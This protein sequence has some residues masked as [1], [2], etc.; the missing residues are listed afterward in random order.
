LKLELAFGVAGMPEFV[1]HGQFDSARAGDVTAGTVQIPKA[2]L[3]LQVTAFIKPAPSVGQT[4]IPA[5]DDSLVQKSGFVFDGVAAVLDD[6][7]ITPGRW[8]IGTNRSGAAAL[9]QSLKDIEILPDIVKDTWSLSTT[10]K[11]FAFLAHMRSYFRTDAETIEH[12]KNLRRVELHRKGQPTNLILHDEAATRLE[13]VRDELPAGTMPNT[14]IGWPPGN[15]SLHGRASIGNLHD[16]G[17]AADFNAAELPNLTDW[18]QKDL[19]YLITG[20]QAWQGAAWT[21][22]KYAEMIKYTE[23]RSRM[24]EPAPDSDLGKTLAKVET[25][26][27]AASERSEAFR[28]SIDTQALLDLR[29]KRRADK[30]GLL[31]RSMATSSWSPRAA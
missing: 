30:S 25:E 22:G 13:A 7:L 10:D 31:R 16:L 15:P 28:S 21:E 24:A 17:L 18:R 26:A 11:K 14:D 6:R 4:V 5:V 23:Q 29:T 3:A 19:I 27:Q 9:R 8:D 1:V 2:K 12:F 20:G